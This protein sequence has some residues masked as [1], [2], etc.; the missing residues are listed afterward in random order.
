M[1]VKGLF[2][3]WL[4]DRMARSL[5]LQWEA[6]AVQELCREYHRMIPWAP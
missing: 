1:P 4:E 3:L 6:I 5:L 2:F